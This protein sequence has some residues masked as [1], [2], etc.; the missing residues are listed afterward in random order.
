MISLHRKYIL[1]QDNTQTIDVVLFLLIIS[2][3]HYV[4]YH[5]QLV[6]EWV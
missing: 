3:Q 5:I 1:I 2:L 6:V 4:G